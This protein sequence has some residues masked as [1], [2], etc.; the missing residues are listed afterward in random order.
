[1]KLSKTIKQG[2]VNLT[3][4]PGGLTLSVGLMGVRVGINTSGKMSFSV[5]PGHG[6]SW[7]K[8]RQVV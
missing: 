5:S 4:S 6:L 8:S 3:A 1:M 7:K 2:P